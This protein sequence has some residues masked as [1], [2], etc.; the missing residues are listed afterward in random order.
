MRSKTIIAIIACAIAGCAYFLISCSTCSCH[1]CSCPQPCECDS[2]DCREGKCKT[3]TCGV[4]SAKLP[5]NLT[6]FIDL[7]NRVIQD[8]DGTSQ[9]DKD[10][11]LVNHLAGIVSKKAWDSNIKHA[12]DCFKVFF[13]P[14]PADPT[15]NGLAQSMDIDLGSYQK[16]QIQKKMDV[17]KD[18]TT[19]VDKNLKVIYQSTVEQHDFIGSDIWGFFN[20]KAKSYCVKD[21]YRNVLIVLTDGYIYHKDNLVDDGNGH[22]TYIT[23]RT[24]RENKELLPCKQDLSDLEVLFIEVD[25]RPK[26][27]FEKIQTTIGKWLA[28]MKVK[29]YGVIETDLPNN[30]KTIIDNFIK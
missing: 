21:G 3:P 30:T 15:I 6:V 12:K 20:T 13:Y 7:S 19:T 28:G 10:T 22:I 18:M 11:V 14:A 1:P 17:A 25:A 24:L 27:D 29:K 9:V 2:K 5:L 16:N 26:N 8:G 23:A 4:D